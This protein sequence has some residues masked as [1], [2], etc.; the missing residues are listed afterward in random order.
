MRVLQDHNNRVCG[1]TAIVYQR[2][3]GP[4]RFVQKHNSEDVGEH[5]REDRSGAP[6]VRGECLRLSTELPSG[7][8]PLQELPFA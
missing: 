3:R 8:W 6:L 7:D 4:W 2:E 5:P 1:V